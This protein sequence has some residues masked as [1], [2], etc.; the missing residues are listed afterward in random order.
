MLSAHGHHFRSNN[1]LEP[2][3]SKLRARIVLPSIMW[4][5]LHLFS[6]R[7]DKSCTASSPKPV[8]LFLGTVG[9][10]LFSPHL[11]TLVEP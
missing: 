7:K 9:A 5:L 3:I 1:H 2:G 6:T 11:Y 8:R 10:S 4:L